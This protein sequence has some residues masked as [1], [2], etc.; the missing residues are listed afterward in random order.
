[1]PE[2]AGA[3]VNGTAL[4]SPIYIDAREIGV[5][6]IVAES[7]VFHSIRDSFERKADSPG[8]WKR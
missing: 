7:N 3:L 8:Y 1:M 5:T 4:R 2:E 6:K